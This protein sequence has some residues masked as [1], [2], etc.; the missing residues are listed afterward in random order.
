MARARV[1][2]FVLE[3]RLADGWV[4]CAACKLYVC[5][6]LERRSHPLL[7]F[8]PRLSLLTRQARLDRNTTFVALGGGV[9]GDMA[10][11]AAAA[12]QRGVHFVQVPTTV[13]SQVGRVGQQPPMVLGD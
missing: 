1:P 2:M 7:R 13:M 10:G 6:M 8:S 5:A 11:F 12:Y 9:I 4:C 3:E